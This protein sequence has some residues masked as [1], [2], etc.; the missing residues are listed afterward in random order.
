MQYPLK[1]LYFAPQVKTRVYLSILYYENFKVRSFTAQ[2]LYTIK[3][4][5]I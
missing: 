2:K 3:F 4:N 5:I 1:D